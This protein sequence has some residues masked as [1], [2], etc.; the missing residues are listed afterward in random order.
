MKP[1]KDIFLEITTTADVPSTP[2][3]LPSCVIKA[4]NDMLD[5]DKRMKRKFSYFDV[6]AKTC[7]FTK[8]HKGHATRKQTVLIGRIKENGLDVDKTIGTLFK[9]YPPKHF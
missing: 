6:T 3:A 5:Y 9:V 4:W 2:T 8:G 1:I 7:T